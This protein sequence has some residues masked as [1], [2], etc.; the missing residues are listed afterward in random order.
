[1]GF[2]AGV[3][4][5]VVGGAAGIA[6]LWGMFRVLQLGEVL[7]TTAQLAAV[8]GVAAFCDVLRDDSGLIAAVIMGLA[9]ANLPGFDVPPRRPFF[10]TIVSLILGLLFI[11]ISATGAL[12]SLRHVVWPALGLTAFLVLIVRPLVVPIAGTDLTRGDRAFIGWMAPH[13]IVAASTASTFSASL[14]AKGIGGASKILPATFIVIVATVTLYVPVS[15][16]LEVIPW[17]D[18]AVGTARALPAA[19]GTAFSATFRLGARQPPGR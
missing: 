10:E 5:G 16:V 19:A 2:L 17:W 11:S 13:G 4:T 6:L 1:M 12:H 15:E 3:G 8:I 18:R 9:V 14:A 7:G